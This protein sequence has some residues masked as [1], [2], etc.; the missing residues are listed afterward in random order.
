MARAESLRATLAGLFTETHIVSSNGR[1]PPLWR[2]IVGRGMTRE[3]AAELAIRVRR[4]SGT[5]MVVLE[6]T[7]NN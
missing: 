6:P 7:P 1:T 5:A 3:E 4:E 2:V